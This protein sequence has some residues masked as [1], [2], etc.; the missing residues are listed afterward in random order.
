LLST[1]KTTSDAAVSWGVHPSLAIRELTSSDLDFA[2]HVRET[3]GWNQPVS[4][5][6]MLLR[7]EPEGCFL[8]S[9]DGEPVGT[10]T[11]TCYGLDLAWIGMVL[12]EPGFRGRGIGRALLERCVAHLAGRGIRSMRLDATPLGLGLY[13]KLGFREEW[14]LTR[15]ERSGEELGGEGERFVEWGAV[16]QGAIDELDARAFGVARGRVLGDLVR[17]SL[18][19]LGDAA[20][21]GGISAFGLLRSG[22]HAR[23]VGPVVA[24]RTD[25]G[26]AMVRELVRRA[27]A[28]RLFWDIPDDNAAAREL[29]GQLGFLEQRRLVRMVLGEILGVVSGDGQDAI[30]DPS[31][32]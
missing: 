21:S 29:A 28:G 24:S 3:V 31:I 17:G 1:C 15:W 7:W 26:L 14:T 25:R 27:G 8:A 13:E 22:V 23:Y 32:G 16:Q 19:A 10:A 11:T 12:V 5:W 6:R 2:D 20:G 4:H 18:C 30:G 9:W